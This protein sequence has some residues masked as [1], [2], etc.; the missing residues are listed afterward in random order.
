ARLWLR[1]EA[2]AALAAELD[3]PDRAVLLDRLAPLAAGLAE[4]VERHRGRGGIRAI[5]GRA[6]AVIKGVRHRGRPGDES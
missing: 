3:P 4:L 2:L 1:T 6:G 5:S